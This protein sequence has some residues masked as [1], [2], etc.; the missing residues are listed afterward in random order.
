MTV[1]GR[2]LARLIGAPEQA[3]LFEDGRE[4]LTVPLRLKGIRIECSRQFGNVV[5]ISTFPSTALR[6]SSNWRVGL[7]QARSGAFTSRYKK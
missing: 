4:H 7:H 6:T 3:E 5:G 1:A 2:L